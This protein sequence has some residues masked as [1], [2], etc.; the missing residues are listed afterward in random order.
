MPRPGVVV[1]PGPGGMGS[2]LRSSETTIDL[3]GSLQ[4]LIGIYDATIGANKREQQDIEGAKTVLNLPG[5][6]NLFGEKPPTV[7]DQGGYAVNVPG[8]PADQEAMNTAVASPDIRKGLLKI[9]ETQHATPK[10]WQFMYNLLQAN[11]EQAYTLQNLKLAGKGGQ[12]ESQYKASLGQEGNLPELEAYSKASKA[13]AGAGLTQTKLEWM[14]KNDPDPVN[15]EKAKS[16][17]DDM[18]QRQVVRAEAFAK[19]RAEWGQGT[20]IDTK[21]NNNL[22]TIT[23]AQA[24]LAND[25]TPGRYIDSMRAD[26]PLTRTALIEDIRGSID[27]T[28]MAVT[29]LQA[30]FNEATRLQL[31]KA[32]QSSD[33]A[34]ALNNVVSGQFGKSLT[35]DQLDYLASVNQLVEQSMAMRSVLGAGQS[36]DDLRRAIKATIPSAGSFSKDYAMKQLDQFEQVLNRVSRGVQRVPLRNDTEKSTVKAGADPLGIR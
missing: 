35:N 23:K 7:S 36:S 1:V 20:Y 30:D 22:V 31:Y 10:E 25:K 4:K 32:V 14:Y 34:T 5:M 29:G 9:W 2:N 21:D 3:L 18:T 33:P 6:R 24:I 28:K 27:N 8:I 15:R 26:K 12:T 11:P 13:G 19:G 17:L 16:V